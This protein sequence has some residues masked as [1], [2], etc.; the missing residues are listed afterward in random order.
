MLSVRMVSCLAE[1]VL[2]HDHYEFSHLF[3]GEYFTRA[4]LYLCEHCFV[5]AIIF[6]LFDILVWPL[7]FH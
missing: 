2:L 6:S 1:G 7:F 5:V 4:C 3:D